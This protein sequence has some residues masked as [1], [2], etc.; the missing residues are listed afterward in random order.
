[1]WGLSVPLAYFLGV[2]LNLGLVGVW[3]ALALDE[4]IRGII[5]LRRWK[6]RKWEKMS[7]VKS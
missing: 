4:W 1:M 6:T 5:M 3:C 7:L 2:H